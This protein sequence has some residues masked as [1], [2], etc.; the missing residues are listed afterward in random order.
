MNVSLLT[1]GKPLKTFEQEK[2]EAKW[3]LRTIGLMVVWKAE[4]D[5]M[6]EVERWWGGQLT[7]SLYNF[8]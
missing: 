8:K 6:E 2:K 5:R 7:T 1:V 3:Y 4:S